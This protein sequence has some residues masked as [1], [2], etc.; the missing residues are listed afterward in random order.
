MLAVVGK[1]FS[2]FENSP[3]QTWVG[4]LLRRTCNGSAAVRKEVKMS[5]PLFFFFL[6][7]KDLRVILPN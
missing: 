6:V 5:N 2:L 4:A 3:F 1:T 7:F